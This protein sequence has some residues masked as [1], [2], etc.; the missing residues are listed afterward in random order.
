MSFWTGLE[1]ITGH[2]A[3]AFRGM[4]MSDWFDN[5]KWQRM[6]R[7]WSGEMN[8]QGKT[9]MIAGVQHGPDVRFTRGGEPMMTNWYTGGRGA[10]ESDTSQIMDHMRQDGSA[11]SVSYQ[12]ISADREED[13]TTMRTRD[14]RVAPRDAGVTTPYPYIDQAQSRLQPYTDQE[15]ANIS[16]APKVPSP[17][18]IPYGGK[19]PYRRPATLMDLPAGGRQRVPSLYD[20]YLSGLRRDQMGAAGFD[21]LTRRMQQSKQ[22]PEELTTA[23][24]Y[25]KGL[26][27]AV[28]SL[29]DAFLPPN[30]MEGGREVWES[31]RDFY[32]PEKDEPSKKTVI[33][34]SAAPDVPDTETVTITEKILGPS[35]HRMG[36][37]KD[38]AADVW[39]NI[40]EDDIIQYWMNQF[41]GN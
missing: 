2:P 29:G 26:Q 20:P 36:A 27:S 12:Q 39:K 10:G 6:P 8:P 18:G 30:V 25:R 11:P 23:G 38:T 24:Q 41:R 4:S 5:E 13:V 9:R 19:N 34:R 16:P 33:K 37:F 35:G 1:A 15:W 21:P 22:V 32:Y 7:T 40:R 17:G 28:G 31:L 14:D 3:G